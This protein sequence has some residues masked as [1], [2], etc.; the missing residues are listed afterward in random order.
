[1]VPFLCSGVP[2][3]HPQKGVPCT[4]HSGV[5]PLGV[6]STDPKRCKVPFASQKSWS[7][8]FGCPYKPPQKGMPCTLP[9]KNNHRVP[10]KHRKNGGTLYPS[11]K[12]PP[13]KKRRSDRDWDRSIGPSASAARVSQS[14]QG[15]LGV[16]TDHQ[17]PDVLQ[18][19]GHVQRRVPGVLQDVQT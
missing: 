13:K 9:L 1:M 15:V 6:P 5:L 12:P 14:P 18:A 7:S 3:N 11:P 17:L 16:G 2:S 8:S 4:T 10:S 19:L